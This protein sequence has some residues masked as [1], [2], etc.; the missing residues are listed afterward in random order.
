V[1]DGRVWK[2]HT[3]ARN[4][5]FTWIDSWYNPKRRHSNSSVGQISPIEFE[6]RQRLKAN[7][8]N[9]TN[10]ANQPAA[11]DYGLPSGCCAPV[12]KPSMYIT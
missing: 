8:I 12:H 9:S 7:E 3:Q 1:I 10:N 2:T 5:I 4:A 6:R 11:S